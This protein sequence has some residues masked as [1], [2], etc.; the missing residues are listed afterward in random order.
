MRV[1]LRYPKTT[2]VHLLPFMTGSLF[3]LLTTPRLPPLSL[4][5]L[6]EA[7]LTHSLIVGRCVYAVQC[8]CA[9]IGCELLHCVASSFVFTYLPLSLS[10]NNPL[11]SVSSSPFSS[12]LSTLLVQKD[13]DLTTSP[14]SFLSVVS[15]RPPSSPP[16][17]L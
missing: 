10:P 16:K 11:L 4:S 8:M 7:V 5:L 6:R 14:L 12:P 17:E 1:R 2:S 3:L 9:G 13:A 15:H